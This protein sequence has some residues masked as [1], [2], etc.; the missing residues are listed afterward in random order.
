MGIIFKVPN[1][2]V[3]PQKMIDETPM[4]YEIFLTKMSLKS[5]DELGMCQWPDL[6]LFNASSNDITNLTDNTFKKCHRLGIIDLSR[7]N[8]A[9]INENT[10][11]GINELFDLD[12]SSN[13][14]SEITGGIMKWLIKI[15]NLRL[16]NNQIKT[17]NKDTFDFN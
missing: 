7:N 5:I 9:T 1:V 14:I 13:K 17:I 16:S 10:F 6:H 4:V 3:I 15:E 11:E 12:L 2:T 8:I